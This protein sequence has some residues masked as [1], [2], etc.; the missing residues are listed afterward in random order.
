M[1]YGHLSEQLDV[2]FIADGCNVRLKWPSNFKPLSEVCDQIQREVCS[3]M[4]HHGDFYIRFKNLSRLFE[5]FNRDSTNRIRSLGVD[6]LLQESQGEYLDGMQISHYLRTLC[7]EGR[8]QHVVIHGQSRYK[9]DNPTQW[10]KY[11]MQCY[12]IAQRLRDVDMAPKN[13][14]QAIVIEHCWYGDERD[15]EWS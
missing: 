8:L 11:F 7:R 6:V 4:W 3:Y 14:D 9:E 15:M 10:P 13:F 5:S 2:V 12:E 1:I